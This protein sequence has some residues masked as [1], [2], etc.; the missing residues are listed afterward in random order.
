MGKHNAVLL[1]DFLDSDVERLKRILNDD[2]VTR[3]LSTKIPS[4]YTTDDAVWWVNEGS[5]GELIKAITV[6]NCLVGCI[7]VNRGEFEYNRSG[8]IGYWLAR[9]YWRQG[10]AS[11]AIQRITNFVFSNTDIVRVFA[12]VFS[13]NEASMQ[14]SLKSDFNQEAVLENAIYKN[15]SFYNNHIFAKIKPSLGATRPL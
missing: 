10:I 12:S 6:D 11:C 1:R 4:P 5:K 15:G 9:E 14:L 8:E 2:S 7:G 3:F 13:D